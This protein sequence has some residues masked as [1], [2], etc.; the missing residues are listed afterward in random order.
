MNAFTRFAALTG[1]TVLLGFAGQ[2]GAATLTQDQVKAKV[3]E[4]GYTNVSDIRLEK[5]HYD[6]TAMKD[7]KKV[8]IDVDA[9][10]GAISPEEE[11]EENEHHG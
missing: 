1:A 2:A 7:G 8:I 5:D 10:T 6:V 4:A 9:K 11:H 3:K